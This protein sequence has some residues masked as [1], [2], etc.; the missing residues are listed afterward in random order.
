MK[1][2]T[3]TRSIY[4]NLTN[5][6]E[7]VIKEI[8][9]L[10][11]QLNNAISQSEPIP[12]SEKSQ[13]ISRAHDEAIS[14]RIHE[15]KHRNVRFQTTQLIAHYQYFELVNAT[16]GLAIQLKDAGVN[17][18]KPGH[19]IIRD[20]CELHYDQAGLITKTNPD[21]GLN[22]LPAIEL[23]AGLC[24]QDFGL[25][26]EKDNSL[27]Y[28]YSS[29][30]FEK[31]P[32]HIEN[33]FDHFLGQDFLEWHKRIPVWG[34]TLSRFFST[35]YLAFK[36]NELDIFIADLKGR[37]LYTDG[38]LTVQRYER[39]YALPLVDPT[40]KIIGLTT[41]ADSFFIDINNT[42]QTFEENTY[43]NIT[44]PRAFNEQFRV[45]KNEKFHHHP[46]GM[47]DKE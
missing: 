36:S 29:A 18:I 1:K 9:A 22:Q 23:I 25:I 13:P 44:S 38:M 11:E 37:N 21:L 24:A 39:D 41:F 12:V 30:R 15:M 5:R 31:T 6:R 46:T 3:P 4:I 20:L 43:L 2:L 34:E 16:E 17:L 42:Q 28:F 26:L 19:I 33:G 27:I 14:E 47:R 35:L 7:Q 45:I 10:H 32:K 40:G 8:N